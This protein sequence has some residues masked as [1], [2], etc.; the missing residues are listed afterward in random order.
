MAELRNK[1]EESLTQEQRSRV[2]ALREANSKAGGAFG[3]DCPESINGGFG[4]IGE[5]STDT[6]ESADALPSTEAELE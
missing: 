5:K 1:W 2:R 4:S 6:T 3:L